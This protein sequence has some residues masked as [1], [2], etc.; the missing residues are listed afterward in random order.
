MKVRKKS[1]NDIRYSICKCAKCGI[2][3]QCTPDFDFYKTVLFPGKLICEECFRDSIQVAFET[4]DGP[5]T[6][7]E[8][9]K[10]SR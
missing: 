5:V 2:V 1:G 8:L 4:A 7:D 9:A 6:K 3:R 10:H